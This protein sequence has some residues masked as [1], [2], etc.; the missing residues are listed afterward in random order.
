MCGESRYVGSVTQLLGADAARPPN[1]F[2][3]SFGQAPHFFVGRDAMLADLRSALNAGPDDD[4][5][6][7]LL[8]GPRGSGK[9]V[10]LSMVED[11]AAEAGWMV[12]SVDASTAGIHD[13]IREQIAWAQEQYEGIP[14]TD[15]RERRTTTVSGLRLWPV[16][17]QREVAE[18]VRAG[19][20]LRRQLT[21]LATHA[22]AQGSAV[23]LSVDELHGGDRDELRRLAADLQHITKRAGLPLAFV[24]AGLSDMKHTLLEDKRMTF[25]HRCGRFDMPPLTASD[26]F[27]CL[28]KTISDA[29]GSFDKSALRTLAEATRSLP[30]RLQLLGYHAWLISGAPFLPIDDHAAHE[31]VTETSRVMADRVYRPTWHDLGDSERSYLRAVAA[32]GGTAEPRAIAE[33]LDHTPSALADIEHRLVNIGCISVRPDG[34]VEFGELMDIGVVNEIADRESRYGGDEGANGARS[35]GRPA[36]PRCN[37]LMPRAKSRCILRLGHPGRHRSQ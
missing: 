1:L 19:W 17:F 23:L 3:P 12:F 13:R 7:S 5:F 26:A 36:G 25:F 24:G 35:G 32:L 20:G 22:A 29:E 14:P 21:T 9:T 4:R 2:T 30:Y 10:T 28:K 8:L 16:S 18:H 15:D 6:T 11:M 31:A 33:M 37:F 27:R 34:Q